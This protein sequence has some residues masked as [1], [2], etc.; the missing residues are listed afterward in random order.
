MILFQI[1]E[2]QEPSEV[3]GF[4]KPEDMT[5]IAILTGSKQWEDL[6]RFVVGK[7]GLD[8]DAPC[9]PEE[10]GEKRGCKDKLW[11]ADEIPYRIINW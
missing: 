2:A 11:T 4:N 6:R 9:C 8:P 10:I 3:V 1:F 7:A 5:Q